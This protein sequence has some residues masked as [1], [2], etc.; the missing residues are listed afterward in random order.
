TLGGIPAVNSSNT[1]SLPSPTTSSPS[2]SSEPTTVDSVAPVGVLGPYQKSG[3]TI[4]ASAFSVRTSS[5]SGVD[6]LHPSISVPI[7]AAFNPL[8]N[9]AL[10][11][12]QIGLLSTP[13]TLLSMMQA[14]AAQ[15]SLMH[16]NRCGDKNGQMVPTMLHQ[17]SA[18]HGNQVSHS[19][20][21][22]I[23]KSLNDNITHL[24]DF[25]LR[26]M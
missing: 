17:L 4:E 9:P 16:Q 26:I 21:T 14:A 2:R 22:F 1:E 24:W 7:A 12:A 3:S 13:N 25:F 19:S 8:L 10:M 6:R 23:E 18:L 11:A 20:S 15:N 5:G